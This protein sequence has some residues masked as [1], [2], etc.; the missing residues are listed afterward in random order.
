MNV[1]HPLT[2]AT[3]IHLHGVPHHLSCRCQPLPSL[4]NTKG[5]VPE[6]LKQSQ[7]LLWDETCQSLLAIKRSTVTRLGGQDSVPE[8]RRGRKLA[9]RGG[10][11]ALL[12]EISSVRAFAAKHLERH[13][14]L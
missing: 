7:I 14:H 11:L 1:H 8:G 9:K 5:S 3:Y 4:N 13:R 2:Y 10:R 6:L 12:G